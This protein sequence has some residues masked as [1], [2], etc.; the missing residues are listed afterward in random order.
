MALRWQQVQD[1][2]GQLFERYVSNERELRNALDAIALKGVGRTIVLTASVH[3]TAPVTLRAAHSGVVLR[4]TSRSY[5]L[6]TA[7][8]YSL[9]SL[10][11]V[12]TGVLVEALTVRDMALGDASVTIPFQCLGSGSS[13]L[14]DNCRLQGSQKAFQ[15]TGGDNVAFRNVQTMSASA[16]SAFN[17]CSNVWVLAC[18]MGL[19]PLSLIAGGTFHITGCSLGGLLANTGAAGILL[20]GNT[21]FGNVDTSAGAGTATIVGNHRNGNTIT[22]AGGDTVASNHL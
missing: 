17:T 15:V 22:A 16:N 19:T 4:A 9:T 10:L 20:T 14:M 18:N 13:F 3:L 7:S 6:F 5:G 21:F 11:T 1:S 12:P 2:G 8:G